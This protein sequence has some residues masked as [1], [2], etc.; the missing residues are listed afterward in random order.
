MHWSKFIVLIPITLLFLGSARVESAQTSLQDIIDFDILD[1]GSPSPKTFRA[2]FRIDLA[3]GWKTYWRTPG[4][5]GLPPHIDFSKSTNL[6]TQN[7]I[8]PSPQIFYE[9]DLRFYG[10]EDELVLPI[11]FLPVDP[12]VPIR[13]KGEIGIGVCKNICI[14]A[15][16]AFDYS[17]DPDRPAHPA[18]A[19]AYAKRPLS[20]SEANIEDVICQ[21]TPLKRGLK[22]TTEI[23]IPG[24]DPETLAVIEPNYPHIWSFDTTTEHRDETLIASSIFMHERLVNFA[25]DRS[26][27]RITIIGDNHA[28]EINGCG[29]Q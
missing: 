22:V 28:I 29:A 19:A 18:V 6:K 13:L 14:P 9:N 27:I 8:W 17:L 11:D 16:F 12:E 15:T 26:K 5:A 23:H 24:T 10:Y 1:G 20:A 21:F 7:I 4:E 3:T 2:G 25:V